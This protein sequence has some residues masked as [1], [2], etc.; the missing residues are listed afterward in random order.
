MSQDVQ[1][2]S[3]SLL[4]EHINALPPLESMSGPRLA[5]EKPTLW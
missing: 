3:H 4:L 5:Q 2:L 1:R